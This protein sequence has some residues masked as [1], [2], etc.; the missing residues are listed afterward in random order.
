MM[1]PNRPFL[2]GLFLAPVLAAGTLWALDLP[3]F[4]PAD[5]KKFTNKQPV[6]V[7]G[8]RGMDE[9][10]EAGDTAAR[11]E[12]S[13]AWLESRKTT[14]GDLSSFLMEGGLLP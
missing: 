14:A 4:R 13:M 2:V 3:K 5:K 12:E 9:P 10:G 8:V 1:N 7:A 6:S 11:D